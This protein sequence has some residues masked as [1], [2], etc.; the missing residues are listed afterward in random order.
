MLSG[1]WGREGDRCIR[2]GF[3]GGTDVWAETQMKWGQQS[4]FLSG[5]RELQAEEQQVQR[6]P[7]CSKDS[8]A[9]GL[10]WVAQI[11]L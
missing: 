1:K 4:V 6:Q 9:S 5:R 8:T 7:W 11:P 3:S 2:E 10:G